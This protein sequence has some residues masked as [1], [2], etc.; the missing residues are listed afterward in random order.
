[1]YGSS[2]EPGADEPSTPHEPL[3]HNAREVDLDDE[4]IEGRPPVSMRGWAARVG[5]MLVAT[6]AVSMSAR[7]M[8]ASSSALQLDQES[9]FDLTADAG[10]AT[11][12]G[13]NGVP[14]AGVVVGEWQKDALLSSI[15]KVGF[16]PFMI[17]GHENSNRE[18]Q[19]F[20]DNAGMDAHSDVF[21]TTGQ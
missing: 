17:F 10:A 13:K 4:N 2:L 3:I 20:W 8:T 14:G 12:P 9:P 7:G 6:G 11:T 18:G 16:N 15:T 19:Y 5:I 1:M 21:N